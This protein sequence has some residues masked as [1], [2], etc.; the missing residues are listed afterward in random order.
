MVRS[1]AA[2][3]RQTRAAVVEVPDFARAAAERAVLADRVTVVGGQGS[4]ALTYGVP[5]PGCAGPG[6]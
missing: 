1:T 2:L 6:V 3:R 4:C 5:V